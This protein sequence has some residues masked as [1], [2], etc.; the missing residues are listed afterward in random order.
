MIRIDIPTELQDRFHR[1]GAAVRE[2]WLA[3]LGAI[4]LAGEIL[5]GTFEGLVARGEK[6]R[7]EGSVPGLELPEELGRE[8]A[9]LR[10]RIGAQVEESWK[11]VLARLNL[12]TREEIADLSRRVEALNARLG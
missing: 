9:A 1:A 8:A 4:D 7:K 5:N 6:A 12:P 3:A 11:E 10:E 2:G